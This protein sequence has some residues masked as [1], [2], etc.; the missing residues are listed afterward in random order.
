MVAPSTAG[1]DMRKEKRTANFR[2]SPRAIPAAM[3]LPERDRPGRVAKPW[4]TPMSRAS[5]SVVFRAFLRPLA[6]RS[7]V[8]STTPVSSRMQLTATG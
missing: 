3:V 5:S 8:K 7:E 1:R 4:A 2:S 6:M